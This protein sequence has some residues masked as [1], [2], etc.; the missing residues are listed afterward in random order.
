MGSP[1]ASGKEE[2]VRTA[3]KISREIER[4][5]GECEMFG[6]GSKLPKRRCSHSAML[7]TQTDLMYSLFSLSF[8]QFHTQ[9]KPL[10]SIL[11]PLQA[12]SFQN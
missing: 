12:I 11:S 7:P 9:L 2:T 1:D 3:R 5:G 6:Y 4:N 8:P 10:L